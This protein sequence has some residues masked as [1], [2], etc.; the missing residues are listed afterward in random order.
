LELRTL[1]AHVEHLRTRYEHGEPLL[2]R[3]GTH[4]LGC[5]GA[6]ICPAYNKAARA[7]LGRIDDEGTPDEMSEHQAIEL[8]LAIEQMQAFIKGA[9]RTMRRYASTHGPL[10]LRDG[11]KWG[12]HDLPVRTMYGSAAVKELATFVGDD[13]ADEAIILS[14]EQSLRA[15]RR[16]KSRGIDLNVDDSL[17]L[18]M[19]R[20]TRAG[21]MKTYPK[22]HWGP[23]K[24]EG[25]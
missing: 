20:S 21:A 3:E 14:Q 15:L 11:R 4:C 16:A 22:G 6:W 18:V 10:D 8:A 23:H 1:I 9:R 17:A 7:L 25:H 13:L 5:G 12:H 19:E 2:F 24:P